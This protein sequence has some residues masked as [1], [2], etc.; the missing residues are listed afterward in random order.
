MPHRPAVALFARAP[1]PGR[2]KSR[3]IGALG[4]EGACAVHRTLAREVWTALAGER[5]LYS[6]RDHPEWRALAG[7]RL[8]LQCDGDL[9]E[10]MLACFEELAAEGY[11][12]VLIVGSDTVLPP[13]ALTG[14]PDPLEEAD[15]VLGPAEDGGYWAIGCRRPDPRMFSGVEWSS[16]HTLA[17]TVAAMKALRW[18]VAYLP[19]T[20]DVDTEADLRRWRQERTMKL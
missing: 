16:A 10:R 8:R 5:F 20:Y 1:V 3:L 7:D 14:W 17:R 4:A 18:S 9:G 6:D 19:V 2:V 11:G 12:P 15:A 13:N